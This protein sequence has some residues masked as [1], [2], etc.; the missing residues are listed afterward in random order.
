MSNGKWCEVENLNIQ[1]WNGKK[2]KLNA[3]NC[4][5]ESIVTTDDH[6]FLAVP[7]KESFSRPGKF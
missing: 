1:N 5:Y 4:F 2:I 7:R 6:K 3:D